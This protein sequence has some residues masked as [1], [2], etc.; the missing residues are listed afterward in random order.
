[1]TVSQ[2]E[3]EINLVSLDQPGLASPGYELWTIRREPW[4]LALSIPQYA[5][6]CAKQPPLP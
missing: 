6:D 3:A 1:M 2:G 4:L 5:G